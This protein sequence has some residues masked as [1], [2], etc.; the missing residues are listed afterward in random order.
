MSEH[1]HGCLSCRPSMVP[2]FEKTDS[3][4][5]DGEKCG[6]YFRVLLD[7]VEPGYTS[8]V[9]EGTEGWVLLAAEGLDVDK[10]HDCP[11]C[12]RR[13]ADGSVEAWSCCLEPRFGRV[14][15]IHGCSADLAAQ[16]KRLAGAL[17]PLV[18]ETDFWQ[19]MFGREVG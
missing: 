13:A 15:V 10:V 2:D 8:G 17:R 3:R 19:A 1:V 4:Y 14:E 9:F 16:I 5:H 18:S 7:G 11:N 12:T 6:R